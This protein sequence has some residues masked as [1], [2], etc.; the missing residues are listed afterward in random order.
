MTLPIIPPYLAHRA[1]VAVI[2]ARYLADAEVRRNSPEMAL[3]EALRVE[4]LDA[5]DPELH[6]GDSHP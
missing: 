5:L 3:L 6:G 1:R 2:F 4:I